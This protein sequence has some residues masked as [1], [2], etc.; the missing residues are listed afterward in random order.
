MVVGV[1]LVLLVVLVVL[2]VLV[3][4]VVLLG[5]MVLVLTTAFTAPGAT[6]TIYDPAANTWSAAPFPPAVSRWHA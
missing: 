3:L 5:L 6:A 2:M 4:L 1:Q